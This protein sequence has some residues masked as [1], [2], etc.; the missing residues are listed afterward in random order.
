MMDLGGKL[1]VIT[2]AG[3]GIGGALMQAF[4]EAGARVIACDRVPLAQQQGMAGQVTFDLADNAASRAAAETILREHGTPDIL[5]NNAGWTR[6]ELLQDV[7][8]Q[9]IELELQL[10]LTGIMN[11]TQGLVPA[12]QARG[13]GS[14]VFVSSVNAFVHYG[15]PVY[16]AA[17]AGIEAYAKALAVELG[18][19]GIRAN[20]VRPGS[21]RTH[22]WDHRLESNPGLVPKVSA[23]YPL[24]RMVLPREVAQ[25]VLF[26]AS[27]LASGITGA[28]MPVDAGASAGNLPFINTVLRGDAPP[29]E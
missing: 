3:G 12:M 23:L 15:N 27:P 4:A 11:F 25:A 10:N 18:G 20:C 22:A 17:K 19:H 29:K 14:V 24:G 28:V 6:T 1:A 26:L 7:T 2:G 8:P 13:Q 21:T 5:I 16:S 9:A